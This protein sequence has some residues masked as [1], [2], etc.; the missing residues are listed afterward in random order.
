[1]N[2]PNTNCKTT[3]I[4]VDAKFCPVCGTLLKDTN[5]DKYNL[6]DKLSD[7]ELMKLAL[8][9]FNSEIEDIKKIS[10]IIAIIMYS[11]VIIAY[12]LTSENRSG[13]FIGLMFCL[14]YTTGA[15]LLIY[16]ILRKI[17]QD[18]LLKKY[19]TKYGIK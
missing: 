8:K 6:V 12:I 13:E 2:C 9:E 11:I 17:K 3:G 1:M 18:K 14:L 16:G 5:A 10:R 19:K 15:I 4:P 7:S